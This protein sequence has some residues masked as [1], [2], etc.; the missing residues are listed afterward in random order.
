MSSVSTAITFLTHR[1]PLMYRIAERSKESEIFFTTMQQFH[2]MQWGQLGSYFRNRSL[3]WTFQVKWTKLVLIYY[4]IWQRILIFQIPYRIYPK[5]LST[6]TYK[7]FWTLGLPVG[8]HSN[9]PCPPV[10]PSLYPSLNISET[11]H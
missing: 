4:L 8:V 2:H 1:E 11:V 9:R 7:P 3:I 5:N 6:S 10:R